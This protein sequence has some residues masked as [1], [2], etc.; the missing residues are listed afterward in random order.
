M[1]AHTQQRRLW[2][3]PGRAFQRQFCTGID[4]LVEWHPHRRP[5]QLYQAPYLQGEEE[6]K[7]DEWQNN[8]EIKRK[9]SVHKDCFSYQVIRNTRM[10]SKSLR[11]RI[12][13]QIYHCKVKIVFNKRLVGIIYFGCRFRGGL[14]LFLPLLIHTAY[15]LSSTMFHF[16]ASAWNPNNIYSISIIFLY[17]W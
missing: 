6:K 11:L 1:V 5:F 13:S 14:C 9:Q 3:S 12:I 16:L 17:V 15:V 8:K 10:H 4:V 2:L 7:I